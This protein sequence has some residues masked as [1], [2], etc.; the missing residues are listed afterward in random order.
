MNGPVHILSGKQLDSLVEQLEDSPHWEVIGKSGQ[1]ALKRYLVDGIRPGSFLCA[2][3]AGD[4]FDAAVCADGVNTNLLF[5]WARLMKEGM[6]DE[7]VGSREA[8]SRW[9]SLGGAKGI[10]SGEPFREY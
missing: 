2:V 10:L 3:L 1:Q 5:N 7:A 4:L 9:V 8:I 6:P